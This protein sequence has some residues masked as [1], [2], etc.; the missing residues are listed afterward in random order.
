MAVVL[1]QDDGSHRKWMLPVPGRNEVYGTAQRHPQKMTVIN[2]P[3]ANIGAPPSRAVANACC[4][5]SFPY[6]CTS[7]SSEQKSAK[8][9]E[10]F[11]EHLRSV[12]QFIVGEYTEVMNA[13]FRVPTSVVCDDLRIRTALEQIRN[14]VAQQKSVAQAEAIKAVERTGN[15]VHFAGMAIRTLLEGKRSGRFDDAIDLLRLIDHKDLCILI[16]RASEV[17]FRP[18]VDDDYWYVLIRALNREEDLRL[19]KGFLDSPHLA[20]QEAA[21]QAIGDIGTPAAVEMLKR[22]AG[23]STRRRVIQKL[24]AELVS[25]LA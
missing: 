11:G 2:V 21:V 4:T 6:Q 12:T 16:E 22:I 15:V 23:D 10:P 8:S 24:A 20:L 25:D 14:S 19:L 1:N 5:G 3:S 17:N 18:A 9:C 13:L 7:N